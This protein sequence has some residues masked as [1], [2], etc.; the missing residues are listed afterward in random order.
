M[1]NYNGFLNEEAKIFL[2]VNVLNFINRY[3]KNGESQIE[4]QEGL[5]NLRMDLN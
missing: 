3:I 5:N 2:R 1:K 4:R